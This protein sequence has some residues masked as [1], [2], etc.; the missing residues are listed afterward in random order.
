MGLGPFVVLISLNGLTL[1]SLIFHLN[2]QNP[3][4]NAAN[5]EQRNNSGKAMYSSHHSNLTDSTYMQ[6]SLNYQF[7]CSKH[8]L[9]KQWVLNLLKYKDELRT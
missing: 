8:I 2:L 3:P 6:H 5:N 7:H 1:R 9:E 4:L